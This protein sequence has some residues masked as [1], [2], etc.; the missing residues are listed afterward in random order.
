MSPDRAGFPS[1]K[2]RPPSIHSVESH[3]EVK[4]MQDTEPFHI[5]GW[6]I[7]KVIKYGEV[8]KALSKAIRGRLDE[9]LRSIPDKT[10]DKTFKFIL[11]LHPMTSDSRNVLSDAQIADV[12]LARP[13]E[14]SDAVQQFVET[15]YD[16]LYVY[17]L[18]GLQVPESPSGLGSLRRRSSQNAKSRNASNPSTPTTP[19]LNDA[20]KDRAETKKKEKDKREMEDQAE[21]QAT[22]AANSVES[23]ICNALYNQ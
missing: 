8:T 11:S 2:G 21:K 22:E 9:E 16:E 7:D 12:D 18:A 17:Y 23:A 15:I 1:L 5:P 13:D 19:T 10:V 4:E 3:A 6:V 20:E 14:T